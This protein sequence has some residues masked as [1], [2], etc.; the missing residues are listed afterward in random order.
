MSGT[1]V[2]SQ[3]ARKTAGPL[4]SLC[5]SVF[6]AGLQAMLSTKGTFVLVLRVDRGTAKAP[7]PSPL[8]LTLPPPASCS[9]TDSP[10]L[11]A[12][13]NQHGCYLCADVSPRMALAQ[14]GH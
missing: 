9:R 7:D 5:W 11:L 10:C 14:P 6:S 12:H 2:P 3:P 4:A 13:V 8:V 1:P